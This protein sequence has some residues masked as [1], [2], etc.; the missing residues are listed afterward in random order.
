MDTHSRDGRLRQLYCRRVPSVD[1]AVV[2]FNSRE[3]IRGC[4]EP[5]LERPNTEIIV[6]DNASTDGTLG[7]LEGLEIR[8]IAMRTNRGFAHGCNAG[9]RA[10]KAPFVL[11][12]NPDAR[13]DREALDRL[14]EVLE[15][16]PQIGAVAPKILHSDG[17]LDFSLRRFPRLRSTYARALFLHRLA[18]R[19]RWSDEVVRDPDAY[20]RPG[21]AEWVSGACVLFRRT[22]LEELDGLDDRFFLYCEDLDLCR[23]IWD[24]GYRVAYEP[25][26]VAVHEGGASAPRT[27]LLPVLAES[28][29]RY[30]RKHTGRAHVAFER[31]GIALESLIR[32]V[33]AR[34]GLAARRGHARALRSAVAGRR[35]PN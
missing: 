22:V 34:G 4:V 9:F 11:L 17:S 27:A 31:S 21:A 5:L 19:A 13:I 30:A 24:R 14:V 10:G 25:G 20:V 3:Q 26:A 1:V 18:P 7:A 6:V 12:L 29:I 2:S 35:L 33:A 15:A 23:R 28:R 8:S 16:D 32:L